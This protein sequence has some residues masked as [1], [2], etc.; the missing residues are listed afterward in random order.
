MSDILWIGLGALALA[1][2]LGLL[3]A[4]DRRRDRIVAAVM[5]A[6]A[7]PGL[8][9]L[10]AVRVRAPVLSR[11]TAVVLDMSACGE[12]EIWQ[13]MRRLSYVLPPN[14]A[15]IIDTPLDRTLPVIVTLRR[16]LHAHGSAR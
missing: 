8:R 2:F 13:A 10:V 5:G 11:R 1:L 9:G 4:R 14:I 12:D 7:T 6:C 3:N 15:V 16:S